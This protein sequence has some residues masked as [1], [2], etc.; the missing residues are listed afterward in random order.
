MAAI[1]DLSDYINIQT[2][3]NNGNPTATFFYKIGRRSNTGL[4]TTTFLLY[5]C[6]D[7]DGI[8]GAGA[9]PSTTCTVC[10]N[11]TQG[12]IPLTAPTG[13]REKFLT[14]AFGMPTSGGSIILVDRLVH[15]RGL[16]GTTTTAQTVQGSTPTPAITRNTGGAGNIIL[17]EI[18]TAIGSTARTITADYIDQDGNSATTVA[19]PFGGA[20]NSE[21]GR[22]MILPLAAGDTGVRSVTSVTINASTGTVGDFGV[23]IVRPIATLNAAVRGAGQYR[24]YVTGLPSTP[25]LLGTE[26]LSLLLIP[27]VTTAS[28]AA[29]IFNHGFIGTVEN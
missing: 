17:V 7:W 12:A 13:G 1:T 5:T 21:A 20:G 14:S 9:N 24:D 10:D 29:Y 6:W 15:I 16:S 19:I 22:A 8:P 18:F 3:G 4:A 27:A 26:C 11:T 28:T 2:G 23:S 25:E